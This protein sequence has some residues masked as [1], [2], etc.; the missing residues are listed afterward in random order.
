MSWAILSRTGRSSIVSG[1]C[2]AL[3]SPSFSGCF[4][5]EKI[6]P[7]PPDAAGAS[8]GSLLIDDFE[9]GN[10][11][12]SM[13]LLAR[14]GCYTFNPTVDP[15]AGQKVSCDL[16]PGFGSSFSLFTAFELQDPL[17]GRQDFTGVGVYTL[18]KKPFDVRPYR[19]LVFSA[20]VDSG[21]AGLPINLTF[22]ASFYCRTASGS[23][24]PFDTSD[25]PTIR[26]STVIGDSWQTLD[27]DLVGFAQPEYQTN[28][29]VGGT[30]ACLARVDGIG[31]QISTNL[32]DG[33]AASGRLYID[34]IA[35]EGCRQ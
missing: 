2:L 32:H 31:F 12:P 17:D 23:V 26:R 24:G 5:V 28:H 6:D 7:G 14:W 9:D 20:R 8:C 3:M 33:K 1:A 10:P 15:D 11:F 4:A 30:P 25:P 13:S 35:L 22:E 29:I 27:L 18:S 19:D 34:D 16:G 21:A